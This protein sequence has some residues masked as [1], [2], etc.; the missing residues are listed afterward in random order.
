[1]TRI[2]CNSKSCILGWVSNNG[3]PFGIMYI[4]SL[5]NETPLY[6]SQHY[7]ISTISISHHIFKIFLIYVISSNNIENIL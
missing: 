1:M 7:I 5:K 2:G 6:T 4:Q 3:Y